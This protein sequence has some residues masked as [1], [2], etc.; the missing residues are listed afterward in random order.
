M[1]DLSKSKPREV[2]AYLR[3]K[4]RELYGDKIENQ[5]SI[6]SSHGHYSI[7]LVGLKESYVF[8]FRKTSIPRIV[9]AMKALSGS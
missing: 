3:E 5:S 9:K 2:E 1:K 4:V 8:N 6:T 7:A